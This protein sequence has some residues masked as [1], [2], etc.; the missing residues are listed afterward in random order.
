MGD[1]VGIPEGQDFLAGQP[2]S[3][4][5]AIDRLTTLIGPVKNVSIGLSLPFGSSTLSI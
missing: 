5:S 2:D 4:P 1:M 3:G